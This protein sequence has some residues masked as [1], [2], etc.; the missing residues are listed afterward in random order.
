MTFENYVAGKL[1]HIFLYFSGPIKTTP[2]RI[3][4]HNLTNRD[5]S[6]LFSDIGCHTDLFLF[7]RYCLKGY[8]KQIFRYCLFNVNLRTNRGQ[9]VFVFGHFVDKLCSFYIIIIFCSS[10]DTIKTPPNE[11]YSNISKRR[12]PERA[13]IRR[14]FWKNEI[15]EKIH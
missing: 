11:L 15:F 12:D 9:L 8:F 2:L 5:F 14:H 3:F 1:F 7:V 6:K 4:T 13:Q 10:Q